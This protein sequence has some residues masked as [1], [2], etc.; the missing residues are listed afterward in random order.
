MPP[1]PWSTPATVH[2]ERVALVSVS[3]GV[4]GAGLGELR[5]GVDSLESAELSRVLLISRA[6][7]RDFAPDRVPVPRGG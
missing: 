3:G 6:P 2:T 5:K 7:M 1:P 4:V